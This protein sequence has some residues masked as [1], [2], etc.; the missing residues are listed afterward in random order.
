MKVPEP[1]K[2]SSGTWFIQLRLGGESISVSALTRADCIRQAQLIKAQHRAGA[3]EKRPDKD[4]TLRD[5]MTQYIEKKRAGLDPST[6]QGYEK[7]RDQYFQQIMDTQIRKINVDAINDAI[8]DEEGRVSRR[9]K[10]LSANTINKA[11][12]LISTVLHR[13]HVALDEQP[14]L[15]EIKKRPVEILSFAEVYPAVKGSSIELECLLAA[16]LSLSM[17]EIRGLTKSKSIREGKLTVCETI[18]DI[19][20][21]PIRK[22]HAKEPDRVRTMPIPPYIQTLID[23]VEG[24][25]ICDKTSQTINKRYQ[26]LLEKAGLPKSSFHKLRHTYASEGARL[27]IQPEILQEGGGWK[28]SHT[29]KTV[30]T[31]TFAASR[32]AAEKQMDDYYTSVINAMSE[33]ENANKNAK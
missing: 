32:L 20:G 26:R 5:A 27:Q 9:G 15:P 14:D 2:L 7:I 8:Y 23:Q 13:N 24:D 17:S 30:Y 12:A 33:A 25:V 28:T 10:P 31:H 19:G 4:L 18:I 22:D 21:K 11:W 6:I 3:R 16:R 1:R 29:M